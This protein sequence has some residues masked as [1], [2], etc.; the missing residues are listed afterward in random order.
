MGDHEYSRGWNPRRRSMQKLLALQTPFTP[1][2]RTWRTLANSL[3]GWWGYH[4]KPPRTMVFILST[5]R[6][7]ST[8]LKALLGQTPDVSHTPEYDFQKAHDAPYR[9]YFQA[10]RHTPQPIVLLKL[11]A[12][13][14]NCFTYP[15]LPAPTAL[16]KVK[17]RAIVLL[18]DPAATVRS[19]MKMYAGSSYYT[20][21]EVSDWLDYW[22]ATY[23]H[24]LEATVAFTDT[25]IVWYNDLTANPIA[26]TADLF[27]WMGSV[28]R[29]GVD[30]YTPPTTGGWRWGKD[31]AGEKI[32]SRRVQPSPLPPHDA[33]DDL[34]ASR[35][36]VQRVL[37]QWYAQR[38]SQR[39]I[40]QPQ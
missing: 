10:T 25:R 1:Q 32:Q 21:F 17:C 15:L 31:D 4:T 35:P 30:T 6:A 22:V 3:R 33:I 38:R 26:V 8:V 19:V 12:P 29:E 18:R 23:M 2:P 5:M 9:W 20:D 37:A 36:D 24:L 27:A 28:R 40:V 11:P 39:A 14:R 13:V 16:P 7:G 34:V